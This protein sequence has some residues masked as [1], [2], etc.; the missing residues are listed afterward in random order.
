MQKYSL[1]S[2]VRNSFTRHRNWSPAWIN[3]DL[4]KSYDVIII[5]GGGHGLATAYYLA[6]NHGVTNI[7]VLERGW[8]GGG[9]VARNTVTIR[10]NY[11]RQESIP[12][13]IKSVEMYEGL[14]KELN[15]NL[16]HSRRSMIDIIQ[17]YPKLRE[18]TRKMY[19]MDIFGSTYIPI[20]V[21]EIRRRIP[22]LTGGGK[23]SRLPII[24]GMV[25]PEGAV[26]R[27]DAVA[28]GY[29]RAA[30]SLGVEIHQNT[31]V[32]SLLKNDDGTIR[33]VSTVKGEIF[34]D[35]V[36]VAVSGH[37][38]QVTD[39]VGLRLP[40]RSFNLSAFVSEPIK[41][42]IDVVVNCPDLGVYLSQTAKGELVIGGAPDPGQSFRRGTNQLVF[43]RTVGAMLELFPSFKK[44]KLL[45]QWGGTVDI[46]PD[47]SPIISE[48]EIPGLYITAGWW[49][50]YKAIPAGG[51]AFA[52]LIATKTPHQLTKSFTLDRFGTL[53]YILEPG[54]TTRV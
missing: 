8:L 25:H 35:R 26:N 36:A 22:T 12:F 19:T 3:H 9:N 7:A 41:P 40:L 47:A 4:K 1:Y 18:I 44:L 53:D 24:A 48:T 38:T 39:T 29:A 42:M 31:K 51:L 11:L 43:E 32:N 21:S 50:G 15:F 16:M 46:T 49:G 13:F 30:S 6:K 10:S 17:T 28:W 27:H 34:A 14:S 20:S 52:N 54:T 45:R 33:G 37:T 5:G 2:L 23:D